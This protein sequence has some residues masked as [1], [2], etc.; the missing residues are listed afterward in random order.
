MASDSVRALDLI[1]QGL[2]VAPNNADLLRG[3]GLNEAALGRWEVALTHLQRARTID[4][5]SVRIAHQ[6]AAILCRLRRYSECREAA[7]HV[8]R[9]A[10]SNFVEIQLKVLAGLSQGDLAGARTTLAAAPP[11]ADSAGFVAYL[12]ADNGLYWV[13][14]EARQSFL[15]GLPP[16]AFDNSR[17]EWGLA[18]AGTYAL[19]RDPARARAYAD[20]ARADLE[21]Q[22]RNTPQNAR[23]HVLLGLALAYLGR[24]REAMQEGERGVALDPISKDQLNG[25][26]IQQQLVRI[27]ILVGEP[28]KALDQL[29]PLLKIPYYLSP[30]WLRID[31]TFDPLRK[32]PRFQR[33]VAAQ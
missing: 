22:I 8:L 15:L 27:Y 14:D 31:P 19:R 3:S 16:S 4:P 32:N 1:T 28:D 26:Y 9:L 21:T 7:D 25:P 11:T 13:L 2:R 24:K 29:E 12:A 23:R 6:L 17:G 20:S 30:G 5:R 10:P 33:L 18:L